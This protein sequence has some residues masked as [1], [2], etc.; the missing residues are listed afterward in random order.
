MNYKIIQNEKIFKDFI[1][2][3]PDCK[4]NEQY[5]VSLLARNKYLKDKTTLPAKV[6]LKRLTASK[7]YLYQKVKQLE[8]EVGAYQNK[9]NPIP[10]ESLAL[11]IS[12][13]PRDLI[14]ATANSLKLFVDLITKEY[15]GYNPHSEI[16]S[17]IQSKKA[18][19]KK[20]FTAFDFDGVDVY[21][22]L[23][24]IKD[25]INIDALHILK[26]RG[27]FHLLVELEKIKPEFKTWYQ[28]ISK[29]EGCD[30]KGS[31]K[32]DDNDD[33]LMPVPGCTQGG[34]IPHFL[35]K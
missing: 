32:E 8:V 14:K 9:G 34:F 5:Y 25:K 4:P 16:L 29:V 13:N 20:H 28:A 15:N 33:S 1:E 30:V 11:Y 10:Q 27:G 26:T 31:E 12:V 17:Q 18:S 2:G 6:Q 22:V 23:E 3:L 24:Q 21:S 35:F 7:D 19:G